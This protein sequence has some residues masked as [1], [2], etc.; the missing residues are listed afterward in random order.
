MGL[1]TLDRTGPDRTGP[2]GNGAA[3]DPLVD[4]FLNIVE[5]NNYQRQKEK[6][7]SWKK[8]RIYKAIQWTSY[9]IMNLQPDSELKG[10]LSW[11]STWK[12]VSRYGI[13]LCWPVLFWLCTQSGHD[14]TVFSPPIGSVLYPRAAFR[15]C[16]T[17]LV[18]NDVAMKV[19]EWWWWTSLNLPRNRW[20]KCFF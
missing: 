6:K 9:W 1:M 13:R 8:R 7:K 4:L 15:S 17:W 3:Q 16:A 2:V 10:Q 12:N 14:Q 19:K 18:I 20:P 11:V 5:I